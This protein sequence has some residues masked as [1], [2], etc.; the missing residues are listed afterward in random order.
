MEGN[1]LEWAS[2]EL[3]GFHR[4]NGALQVDKTVMALGNVGG[5]GEG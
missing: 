1:L 5:R 2:Q 3:V 4:A